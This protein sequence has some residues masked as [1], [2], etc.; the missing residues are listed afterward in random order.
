MF[1]LARGSCRHLRAR[2]TPRLRHNVLKSHLTKGIFPAVLILVFY[3]RFFHHNDRNIRANMPRYV[4]KTSTTQTSISKYFGGLSSSGGGASKTQC[5]IKKKS[6]ELLRSKVRG[7]SWCT[8][9]HARTYGLLM[10]LVLQEELCTDGDVSGLPKKRA[11]ISPQ[12]FECETASCET[13]KSKC[14][15]L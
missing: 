4:K 6:V 2:M 10:N 13:T 5:G 3:T 1:W 14:L 11:K 12:D 7:T 8:H 9:T 15:H